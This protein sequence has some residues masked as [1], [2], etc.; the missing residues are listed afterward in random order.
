[1]IKNNLSNNSKNLK[2]EPHVSIGMPVYNGGL[3]LHNTLDSLLSQTFKNFELIISDN[4]STDNT[5]KICQEYVKKDKRVSYFKQSH[6]IGALPNFHFVLDKANNE[7]FM[8]N[9]AD[10]LRD[11]EFLEKMVKILVV[12]KKLVGS[13]SKAEFYNDIEKGIKKTTNEKSVN[14]FLLKFRYF[15]KP[16]ELFSLEGSYDKKVK[17]FLKKSKTWLFYGLFRTEEL[18][19]SWVNDELIGIGVIVIVNILK[20]GNIRIVDET[21]TYFYDG[22]SS[23]KGIIHLSKLFDLTLFEK[24]FLFYPLTINCKKSLGNKIFLKNID[25]FIQL[26][27]WGFITLLID[28]IQNSK[29]NLHPKKE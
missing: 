22:G 15:L 6:H 25:Y 17:S 3:F 8:W 13:M 1:M 2:K 18:R 29:R 5:E 16:G 9:A 10:D 23:K 28:L 20:Y 27:V 21:L 11:K 4:A 12:D 26:N 19:K 7:F 14:N 24:I